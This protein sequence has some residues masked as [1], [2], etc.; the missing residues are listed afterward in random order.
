MVS[1]SVRLPDSRA[2]DLQP[3]RGPGAAAVL[4]RLHAIARGQFPTAINQAYAAPRWI[5]EHG[6]E[7]GVDGSRL[8]V[9]GNSV[10]GNMATVVAIKAKEAELRSC[11]FRRLCGL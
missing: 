11:V 9:A 2:S 7:I 5:A 4:R 1:A 8:A 10:G 3:C 6:K